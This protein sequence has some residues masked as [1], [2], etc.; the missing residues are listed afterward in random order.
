MIAEIEALEGASA[1]R[2][3]YWI[4]SVRTITWSVLVR[5]VRT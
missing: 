2:A 4:V 3:V 5:L 1:D